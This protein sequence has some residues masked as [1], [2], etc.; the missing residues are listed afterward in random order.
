MTTDETATAKIVSNGTSNGSAAAA[1]Q[2]MLAYRAP[3]LLQPHH[4]RQAFK[5]AH[6]G[7]IPPLMGFYMGFASTAASKLVAQLGADLVWIDWEHASMNVET[8]TQV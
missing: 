2:G 7:K 1:P 5:D 3:S 8:M 6:E 4:A